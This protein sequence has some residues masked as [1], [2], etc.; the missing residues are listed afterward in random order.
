V[1]RSL[2]R[3]SAPVLTLALAAT[4]SACGSSSSS[5]SS[6]SPSGS[7]KSSA[8]APIAPSSGNTIT[9]LQGTAPDFLDPGQ[10]YTT[11]SANADWI[12]YT[13]LVT[14]AHANGTAGGKVIPGL[15]TNVGKVSPNGK[16]YS[17]TMRKGL[18]Y[19]DGSPV[20]AS[21][22][23]STIQRSIKANW[24]GKS[25]FVGNIV[26]AK[27]FD[28]GKAP[29]ISGIVADD[30]TGK[31]K[32]KLLAPYGAFLN[33]LAFPAAGL[34][35]ASTPVSNQS[36]KPPP[37]V[38]PYEIKNVVPN[39]SYSV[40]RNPNWAK[41]A[42]PG[43]PAGHVDVNVKIISNTQTEGQ[44][45]LNN[46]ADI[47][48]WADQ[49][50]PSLAPQIQSQAAGRFAKMPTVST[51]YFFLNTKIKPFSNQAAREAVNLALDRR[52]L[53]RLAGGN[54]AEDCYFLPTG[55][56]G[57]PTAPCPYGDP[58]SAPN[59]AKAKAMVQQSGMAGT[60]ITVW[61]QTRSPRKEYIDYYT[62]VLNQIGFKATEKIIADATYFTTIGNATT[63]AQTGFAD[64]NQDFPNPSDF[65][66][67]MD[68]TAIQ[69][70]NNQNFSL[71]NDPHIQSE[72]KVLNKVPTTQLASVAGRWSALDQ[73]VAQKAYVAV[74]G[75]EKAPKFFSTRIKFGATVFHPLYGNDWTTVQV[76]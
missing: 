51:Y 30:A 36:N 25:F 53:S 8:A 44:D 76:K 73:Y 37:G 14:Y 55:I 54:I 47:F 67:L 75:A 52:A 2:S 49:L 32:I 63:K 60:P 31:I 10:G 58:K 40:M 7:S 19:S 59:L 15:A 45:V 41:D 42:I 34:V 17:F 27:E 74:F 3:L 70:Q 50:P 29:A 22:F 16:T 20:K 33:V 11:Q 48:D 62:N 35:P 65:Y 56:I 39:Q 4:L 61:G 66:L 18:V 24:G 69:P 5:S 71:V 12:S 13:G 21:D 57:H 38:G 6:S 26:G 64:W 68:G 43:I 28:S 9:V 46:T 1:H 23:K 72:L